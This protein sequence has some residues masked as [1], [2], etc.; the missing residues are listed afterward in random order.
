MRFIKTVRA[1]LSDSH[2]LI[3][4]FVLLC[5]LTLLILLR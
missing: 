2:F 4:L 3:P 1:I 5:G